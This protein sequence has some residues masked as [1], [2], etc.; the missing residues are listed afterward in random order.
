MEPNAAR[1][2]GC[3]HLDL[4][5]CSSAGHGPGAGALLGWAAEMSSAVTL[6]DI[7]LS[8]DALDIACLICAAVALARHNPLTALLA[9]LIEV[10]RLSPPGFPL[11]ER[12]L[13]RNAAPPSRASLILPALERRRRAQIAQQGAIEIDGT[14]NVQ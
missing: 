14:R 8:L 4:L 6:A 13:E 9:S 7:A 1:K 12:D 2:R 11:F 5:R 10:A 3:P